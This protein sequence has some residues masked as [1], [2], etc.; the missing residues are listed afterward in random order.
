MEDRFGDLRKA[1]DQTDAELLRLINNRMELSCKVGRIKA[2]EGLR[3]FDPC[4]EEAILERLAKANPGPIAE[5]S[6]RSIYREIFSASR[7]LQYNLQVAYLGPEWTYSHLA[8]LSLFGH[9]ARYLPSPVLEDVFDNL[10]KAKAHLA[11]V[12]IENSLQGGVG[13]TL[14]L[15]YERDV[16]ILHECYL[17]IAHYLCGRSG[18]MEELNRLYGHPQAIEQCRKFI[19]E[20]LRHVEFFECSSSVQAARLAAGDRSSAAV[21]NLH[22]AF[23]HGLQVLAERIED[24]PENTTR[25]FVLGSQLNSPTGNDKTSILFAVPDHPGALHTA[26]EGFALFKVNMTRIES[27]PNPIRSWQYLFFADL[28]GHFDD[29]SVGNALD[30]LKKQTT[31]LKILGSYPSKDPRHPIRLDREQMRSL[32]AQ[33]P[34]LSHEVR[35]VNSHE[36]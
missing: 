32:A 26:L 25:F 1:I 17:E 34:R 10:M 14:D 7:L 19:L 20:N 33:P 16:N 8:A 21:C 6:L 31:Y 30:Y 2:K 24:H 12:P 22:A 5:A 36:A 28:E 29:E 9:S 35:L 23:Q 13:H 3:L 18:P 15:L 27:R 11:V 4:R